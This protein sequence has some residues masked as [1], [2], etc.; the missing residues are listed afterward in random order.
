MSDKHPTE[1]STALIIGGEV[2]T[3]GLAVSGKLFVFTPSQMQ[4]LLNLQKMKNVTAAALSV[5]KPEDWANNFLRSRKFKTY[6]SCKMEEFSVKN[7]L[8]VE[9]WYQFGK[10]VADGYKEFYRL[11]CAGCS[12]QGVLNTYEVE[13]AR[14]DD[15]LTA[16]VEC[17]VC[18]KITE[19]KLERQD[20]KP[21]REQVVAWQD[22]GSRL[23]PKVDRVHHSY[24]NSEIIFESS[25]DKT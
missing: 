20:F 23:I 5:D 15:M 1:N 6:I 11:E 13:S 16:N 2:K 9:W 3:V 24:E 18:F 8:T 17:P 4:F 10:Q 12:Y 7:G 19:P 21:T 14:S 22:L 25:G